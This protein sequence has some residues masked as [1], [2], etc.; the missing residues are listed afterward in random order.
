MGQPCYAFTVY[1]KKLQNECTVLIIKL[2]LLMMM[3]VFRFL[4]LYALT[5]L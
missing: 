3:V 1:F 4:T 2:L 5:A